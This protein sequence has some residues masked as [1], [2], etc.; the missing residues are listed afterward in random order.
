MVSAEHALL[1]DANATFH[2]NFMSNRKT[3]SANAFYYGRISLMA[4]SSASR[5]GM[6]FFWP[7]IFNAS[8]GKT[9]AI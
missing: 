1:V 6:S 4:I 7:I 5:F 3:V 8:R 9:V 2:F